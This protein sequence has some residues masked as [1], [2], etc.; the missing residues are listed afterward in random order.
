MYKAVLTEA[1][2]VEDLHTWPDAHLLRRLWLS[3]WLPPQLRQRWKDAFPELATIHS[4][5]T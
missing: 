3:L 2:T 5:A 4:N 1:A